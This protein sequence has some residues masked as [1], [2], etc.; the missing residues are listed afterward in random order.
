MLTESY[1]KSVELPSSGR[2][3]PRKRYSL[4]ETGTAFLLDQCSE[5]AAALQTAI[6]GL[7][8]AVVNAPS[9]AIT[10]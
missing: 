8:V 5:M 7:G 4:T 2:G 10:L 9:A 3:R 1:L 6:A